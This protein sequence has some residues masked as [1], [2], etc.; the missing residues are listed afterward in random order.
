MMQIC[1][2]NVKIKKE[3]TRN[4]DNGDMIFHSRE[5]G[6]NGDNRDILLPQGPK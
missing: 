1:H 4:G 3:L 2:E 5:W 6:H